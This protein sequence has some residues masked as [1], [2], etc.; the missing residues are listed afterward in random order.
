MFDLHTHVLPGIDDG[1]P[2]LAASVA[3][4]AAAAADGTRVIAATPHLRSDHP[5]VDPRRLAAGVAELKEAIARE[6]IAADIIPGSELDLS[7]AM[8]AGDEELRLASLAQRGSDLLL[9]CPYGELP[10][11]LEDMLFGLVARGYRITLAHPERNPTFQRDRRRLAALIDR[12]ALVQVTASALT[13]DGRS[14]RSARMAREL[15]SDGAAHVIASDMHGSALDRSSLAEGLAAARVIAGQRADWMVTDAPAA[16]LAGET[17]PPMPSAQ[18]SRPRRR[19]WS[20]AGR[21]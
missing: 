1:P 14:S 18:S 21:I 12:G 10:P 13:G 2:D 7:W 8:H 19:F 20:R 5:R 6:R 11:L 3:L 15:V 17:L 4:V 16:I 9:E